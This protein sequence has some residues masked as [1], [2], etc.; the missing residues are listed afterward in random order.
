[1][2]LLTPKSSLHF[3]N[4]SY[5]NLPRHVRAEREP[6]ADISSA[7]ASSRGIETGQ[8]VRVQ[9]RHGELTVKARVGDRVRAGVVA[10]PSGW[11][12]GLSVNADRRRPR[13]WSGGADTDTCVDVARSPD[14]AHARSVR[15]R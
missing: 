13:Q 12:G 15:T 11:W 2:V 6:F 14:N 3:M 5:A 1:L 4:S 7:D 8:L 10:I 9:S